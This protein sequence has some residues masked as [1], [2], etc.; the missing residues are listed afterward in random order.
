MKISVIVP[1]HNTGKYLS[2]CI[3]SI[4]S[5]SFTDFQLILS[6]DDSTDDSAEICRRYRSKD[7]RIV[8][9]PSNGRG[10]SRARNTGLDIAR[11]EYIAFVDSDDC[12]SPFYLEKL[13]DLCEKN[14]N[15]LSVCGYALNDETTPPERVGVPLMAYPDEIIPQR[16]YFLRLYTKMEIM[17]VVVWGKLYHRSIFDNVRFADGKICEDEG[18]IHHIVDKVDSAAVCAQPLYFYTQRAGSIMSASA[19][20]QRMDI[21][22]FLQ[23]RIDY[24]AG[25]GMYDLVFLTMKNYLVKCLQF[26]NYLPEKDYKRLTMHMFDAMMSRRIKNPV[27][28]KRFLLKLLR[29]RLLPSSF[30]DV[31]G[32]EFMYG[33]N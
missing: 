13:L 25:R 4:L 31:D 2:R 32:N 14:G 6:D 12:V 20:L 18:I 22:P 9:V 26:Y 16:D 19:A 24:F 30:K 3:D 7:S 1:V 15:K 27:K 29:Y 11:G 23:D 28:N 33:K 5:Q 17:Y 10:V 8:F 21:F